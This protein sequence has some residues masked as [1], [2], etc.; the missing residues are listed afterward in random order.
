LKKEN[1]IILLIFYLFVGPGPA[2]FFLNKYTISFFPLLSLIAI[3]FILRTEIKEFDFNRNLKNPD[4]YKWQFWGLK[5]CL[6]AHAL[7][8]LIFGSSTIITDDLIKNYLIM[9]LY[10]VIIGSVIEEIVYRKIIFGGLDKKYNFW[11]GAIVSSLI[12][13]LGHLSPERLPAYFLTGLVLCFVYKKSGTLTASILI[14]STLNFIAIL[15]RT[16]K[17]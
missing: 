17:G 3:L 13:S 15:V 10:S 14:H 5:Y 4:V 9:P 16:L 8:S 11:A 7:N 6:F 12:F 2:L 1:L